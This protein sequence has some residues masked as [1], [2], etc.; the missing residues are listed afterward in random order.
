MD[1]TGLLLSGPRGAREE[2]A[3]WNPDHGGGPLRSG[4]QALTRA[5]SLAPP[6]PAPREWTAGT[7]GWPAEDSDLSPKTG[8][9]T[10]ACQYFSQLFKYIICEM[11][12]KMTR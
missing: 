8:L 12:F 7:A 5:C 6:P 2:G 10:R 11:Q 9:V 3:A 1:G 4:R